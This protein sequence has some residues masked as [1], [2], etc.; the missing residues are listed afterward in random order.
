MKKDHCTIKNF[1]NI[2]F[3]I[4]ALTLALKQF[5]VQLLLIPFTNE[6]FEAQGHGVT[7]LCSPNLGG[8][9]GI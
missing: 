5:N 8:V 4:K 6:I 2:V 3:C 1:L 9:I 7:C